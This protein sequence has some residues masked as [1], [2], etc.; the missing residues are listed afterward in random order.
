MLIYFCSISF[1][2]VII[3]RELR[4]RAEGKS[5]S[6]NTGASLSVE[7]ANTFAKSEKRA[8]MKLSSMLKTWF[9][10]RT[11]K[12]RR[13]NFPPPASSMCVRKEGDF[14]VAIFPYHRRDFLPLF[15]VCCIIT[16]FPTRT[17]L[18]TALYI[19]RPSRRRAIYFMI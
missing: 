5:D 16:L 19:R 10:L 11:S 8:R 6:E 15:P 4:E 9:V 18:F 13:M 7:D 1:K 14:Y 12:T 2:S 17:N 3:Y